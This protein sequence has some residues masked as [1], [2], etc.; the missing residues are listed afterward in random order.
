MANLAYIQ[1]VR[2]C[3]QRCRFCSNPANGRD[4][5]LPRAKSLLRRYHRQG[6]DGV[7]LTGGEPTLYK[8]LCELITYAAGL[9]LPCRLITNAQ[10][11]A[12]PA[13][14]GRLMTAGLRHIHVSVHSHLRAVQSF[15][16]GNP[17]SL[18]NIV[19][20]LALLSRRDVSVDINQTIC[21]QNADHLHLTVRWLCERFPFV[22]HFSWTYLDTSGKRVAE[23]PETVPTLR[24][25]RRSL[26]LAMRYLT[27]TK[28]T[29][30]I[31][32]VPLCYMGEFSH[33]STE[34][35]AIIKG[36]KRA[37]DFLDARRHYRERRW[38]HGYSK[39]EACRACSL[40]AIC[41]G[42]WT[43][44]GACYDPAELVAQKRDPR[45][46]VRRVLADS[47]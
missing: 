29:F 16:S 2:R 47:P 6:Y 31:E 36:E 44:G 8:P 5:G 10:R 20:T 19:R 21:A 24:G 38:R 23:H 35:R 13:Y 1:L 34:T 9:G 46:I 37:I 28:R 27:R 11:T 15:L 43:L 32:K 42:L 39:P 14:L 7:I 3:G 26:L 4:L 12:D 18:A 40:T 30:R 33:C 22:R 41:A 45:P 17:D 25:S